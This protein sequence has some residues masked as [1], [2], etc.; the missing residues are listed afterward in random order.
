MNCTWVER[1]L[2]EYHDHMLD[3]QTIDAIAEHLK[4]CASCSALLSDYERFDRLIAELP[5]AEP[6]PALHDRIFSS[7]EFR[8]IVRPTDAPPRAVP[9]QPTPPTHAWRRI[10]QII[11][12]LVLLA[13][14]GTV[15]ATIAARNF[16][17]PQPFVSCP[18]APAGQRVIYLDGKALKSAGALLTC[19]SR[20]AVGTWSVSPNGALVAYVDRTTGRVHI[21][22]AQGTSDRV[23]TTGT[24]TV[25]ALL[26][27][28][29]SSSIAIAGATSQGLTIWF[30]AHGASAVDA[31]AA[32]SISGAITKAEW[33]PDSQSLA[34]AVKASSGQSAL[35]VASSGSGSVT[36]IAQGAPI[37]QIGWTSGASPQVVWESFDGVTHFGLQSVASTIDMPGQVVAAWSSATNEWAVAGANSPVSA[38]DPL[39]GKSRTLAQVVHVTSLVWSPDGKSLAIVSSNATLTVITAHGAVQLTQHLTS[40]PVA[41]SPDGSKIAFVAGTLVSVADLATDAV[42][43]VHPLGI[44]AALGLAW[45][46]D[47]RQLAIWS[48]STITV[49]GA[50]GSNAVTFTYSGSADAVPPQWS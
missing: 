31:S 32:L 38:L 8:D 16:S 9:I 30:A 18:A 3:A 35:F 48:Q 20:I 29:D 43:D 28:P 21:V 12:I 10:T 45:S 41:F 39:T 5:V 6:S 42:V 25:D 26:W 47:N 11:A 15:V 24:G 1:N 40:L 34:I 23:L 19:D 17:G 2:S 46:G 44:S 22:T 37:E 4:T 50:D 13:G 49:V 14:A 36:Q 33:S 7:P 27:S